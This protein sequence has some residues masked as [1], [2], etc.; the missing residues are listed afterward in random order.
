MAFF[1]LASNT[2]RIFIRLAMMKQVEVWRSNNP[3]GFKNVFNESCIISRKI[4]IVVQSVFET[5]ET[6]HCVHSQKT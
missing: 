5:K 1:A 3:S 6:L 2:T 4:D